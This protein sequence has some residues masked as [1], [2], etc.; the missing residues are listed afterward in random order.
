MVTERFSLRDR[1]DMQRVMIE[2]C[3]K[4]VSVMFLRSV[5]AIAGRIIPSEYVKL[6]CSVMSPVF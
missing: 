5:T 4:K 3:G 1:T 2:V 6:S